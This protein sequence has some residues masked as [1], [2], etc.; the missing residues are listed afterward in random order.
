[1]SAPLA[2]MI[3][4]RFVSLTIGVCTVL[5]MTACSASPSNQN[6][7]FSYNQQYAAP[8]GNFVPGAYADVTNNSALYIMPSMGSAFSSQVGAGRLVKI[9]RCEP[10]DGLWCL[11]EAHSDASVNGWIRGQDLR[12]K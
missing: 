2:S 9:I 6:N 4:K 1:M 10:N 12:A 11:I 7:Q 8:A 3:T 5:A